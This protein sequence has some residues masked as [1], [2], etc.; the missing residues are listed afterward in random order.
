MSSL[1][2]IQKYLYSLGHGFYS[3]SPMN[4][5]FRARLADA[6]GSYR[7]GFDVTSGVILCRLTSTITSLL[8]ALFQRNEKDCCSS[9]LQT[10]YR[11][12]VQKSIQRSESSG[13]PHQVYRS[14]IGWLAEGIVAY[15]SLDRRNN[16]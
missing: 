5:S 1:Y 9:T 3:R 4:L 14:C 16:C 7:V 15:S 2:Y 10:K 11:Q 13:F 12:D 6:S 8:A